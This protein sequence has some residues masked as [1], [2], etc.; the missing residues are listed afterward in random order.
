M[1]DAEDYAALAK[2]KAAL[3]RALGSAVSR[4]AQ[5]KSSAAAP[6]VSQSDS[7]ASSVKAEDIKNAVVWAEILGPP[8]AKKPYGR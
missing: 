7:L 4:A 5:G 8:R 1:D 6:L 2:Q 3:E